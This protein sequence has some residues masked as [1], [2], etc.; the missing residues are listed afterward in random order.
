MCVV[1]ERVT[2]RPSLAHV[3]FTFAVMQVFLFSGLAYALSIGQN[4]AAKHYRIKTMQ[5]RDGKKQYFVAK[6]KFDSI[7]DMLD[8]FKSKRSLLSTA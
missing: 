4:N 5:S 7:P 6:K 8:F 2:V 3:S 1:G